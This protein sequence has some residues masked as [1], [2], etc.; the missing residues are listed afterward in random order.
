MNYLGHMY[1][2][3]KDAE[4]MLGNFI[5]DAVKGNQIDSFPDPVKRGILL[6]RKIDAFTDHHSSSRALNRLLNPHFRKYSGVVVDMYYDHFLARN[7]TTF[8][9]EDLKS[10]TEANYRILQRHFLQLPA[11]SRRILPFMMKD[12]WLMAYASFA[13]LDQAFRGIARRTPFYSGMEKGVAVLRDHYAECRACF[14]C[15]MPDVTAFV[16]E[17]KERM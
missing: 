7:W 8:S 9:S 11:R 4:L 5:A 2:S 3:G 6:H 15:F 12:N 13:G 14:E 17:E 16:A 10:F 1:L